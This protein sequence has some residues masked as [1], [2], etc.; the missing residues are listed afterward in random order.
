M[1]C[2]ESKTILKPYDENYC[3][4][5]E[6]HIIAC[7]RI[8]HD[9][10]YSSTRKWLHLQILEPHQNCKCIISAQGSFTRSLFPVLIGVR[11]DEIKP[12]TVFHWS[13]TSVIYFHLMRNRSK[14]DSAKLY[15]KYLRRKVGKDIA[16][17]VCDKVVFD[18]DDW[19]CQ[20]ENKILRDW[21]RNNLKSS[22]QDHEKQLKKYREKRVRIDE[23]IEFF[24]GVIDKK[25][26]ELNEM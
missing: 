20:A 8:I 1:R 21:R 11:L 19:P 14:I 25:R 9:I 16:K 7:K 6:K 26:K 18:D 17:L 13:F 12:H 22:I 23:G 15:Y 24:I 2:L 3:F 10:L 5:K 4:I